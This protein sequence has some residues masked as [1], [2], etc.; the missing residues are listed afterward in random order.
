MP[1]K[2][3][4]KQ[5]DQEI[6]PQEPLKTV[7]QEDMEDRE[8]VDGK[9]PCNVA[10]CALPHADTQLQSRYADYGADAHELVQCL[11]ADKIEAGLCTAP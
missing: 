9:A 5:N 10:C 11:I 3:E 2:L 4:E 7:N 8:R 1:W 6:E